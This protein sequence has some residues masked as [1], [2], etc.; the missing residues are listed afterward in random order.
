MQ[1]DLLKIPTV[2]LIFYQVV[3]AVGTLRIE[4]VPHFP[5]LL[6]FSTIATLGVSYLITLCGPLRY[7]TGLP[8]TSGSC[9]PGKVWK[10][11]MPGMVLALILIVEVVLGNV[12]DNF[13][14]I[15]FYSARLYDVDTLDRTFEVSKDWKES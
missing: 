12:L 11:L 1:G 7:F 4:G 10:G 9:I 13:H 2:V 5:F 8:T 3:I 6:F 15:P 14:S